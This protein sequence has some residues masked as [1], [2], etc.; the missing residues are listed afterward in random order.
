MEIT[1]SKEGS[2]GPFLMSQ[3]SHLGNRHLFFRL[4]SVVYFLSF[5]YAHTWRDPKEYLLPQILMTGFDFICIWALHALLKSCN[6]SPTNETRQCLALYLGFQHGAVSVAV[7]SPPTLGNESLISWVRVLESE[8]QE[9]AAVT[10]LLLFRI[11]ILL[12]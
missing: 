4:S 1:I 9:I 3:K 10:K 11:F 7:G 12:F 6:I 5:Y 8:L 2:E